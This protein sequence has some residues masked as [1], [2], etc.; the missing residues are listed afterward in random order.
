METK[1]VVTAEAVQKL[2]DITSAGVM[3]C[4]K[5]LIEANGDM[6]A[7]AKII[8]EKGLAKMEKRANRETGAGL[9][10]TYVHNDRIG[11][12]LRLSAETD[13]VVRSE[14]F[15]ELA[16]DLAMHIAAAAPKNVE[17]LM[18]QAYIKDES[19]TIKDIVGDVIAKVGENVAVGEFYRIE[20]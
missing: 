6:D 14:P 11:V 18:A 9:V 3:D 17:E 5:A 2:R 20:A 4:R 15:K 16:H 1:T 19:R 8:R 13:F 12:M 10:E 7:A